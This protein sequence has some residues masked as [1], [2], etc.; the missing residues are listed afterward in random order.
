[1]VVPRRLF[2][3]VRRALL[4][5]IVSWWLLIDVVFVVA[6]W[7]LSV[8]VDVC[9]RCSLLFFCCCVML[10]LALFVRCVSF[11]LKGSTFLVMCVDDGCWCSLPLL[12]VVAV[13]RCVCIVPQRCCVMVAAD[14]AR[15]LVWLSLVG[16]CVLRA[17]AC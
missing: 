4:C 7:L 5:Y 15:L 11:V 8:A 12:V 10:F 9:S 2:V 17:V 14:C 3:V 16:C 13:C 1:M 6:R